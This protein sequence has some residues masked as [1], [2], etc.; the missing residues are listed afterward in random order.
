M[1]RVGEEPIILCFI[2]SVTPDF[3]NFVLFLV[4]GLRRVAES[5]G[6]YIEYQKFLSVSFL[7]ETK[8]KLFLL[9]LRKL[10]SIILLLPISMFIPLTLWCFLSLV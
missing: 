7:V 8:G 9:L 3:H 10:L 4:N 6:I 1:R 5:V 2:C